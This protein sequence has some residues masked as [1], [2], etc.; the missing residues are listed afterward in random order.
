M[1]NSKHQKPNAKNIPTL[2]YPARHE[3]TGDSTAGWALH[4]GPVEQ[5]KMKEGLVFSV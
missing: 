4:E 5:E 1:K 3:G 2:K